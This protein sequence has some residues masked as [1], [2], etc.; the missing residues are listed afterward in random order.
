MS[1][2]DKIDELTEA[3]KANTAALLAQGSS[4]PTEKPAKEPKKE[5]AAQKR[6]RE[7]AEKK[8][9]EEA[10]AAEESEEETIEEETEDEVTIKEVR[11]VARP[12]IKAGKMEEITDI[13]AEFGADSITELD[14][15][16]FGAV[17]A[18]LKKIKK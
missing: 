2:E 15:E 3:V 18:R 13:L 11:A 12:L 6:K 5:T 14:E 1:L 7:A 8:A 10:A 9:A 16:H 4:T 17:L